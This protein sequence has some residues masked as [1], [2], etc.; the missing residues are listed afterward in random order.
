MGLRSRRRE[1]LI[2]LLLVVGTCVS[3]IGGILLG[4][5]IGGKPGALGAVYGLLGGSV[6]LVLFQ[7]RAHDKVRK[8]EQV[9]KLG[10]CNYYRCVHHVSGCGAGH[11][12]PS[13]GSESSDCPW[14]AEMKP[15]SSPAPK[16]KVMRT[17]LVEDGP[18]YRI[19]VLEPSLVEPSS[20]GNGPR[21]P[22]AVRDRHPE[23]PP[24]TLRVEDID[25]PPEEE[26]A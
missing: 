13:M 17:M 8:A 24:G 7:L 18:G 26:E 9:T 25:N 1:L 20:D 6:V 10:G 23:I 21:P 2:D 4:G 14:F 22:P 12:G 11:E 19:K 16:P 15:P 5:L 3:L